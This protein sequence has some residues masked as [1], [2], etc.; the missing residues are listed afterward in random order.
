VFLRIT[1]PENAKVGDQFEFRLLQIGETDQRVIGGSSY[2]IE[3][4]PKTN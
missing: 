2:R 4:V 1:L 3:V